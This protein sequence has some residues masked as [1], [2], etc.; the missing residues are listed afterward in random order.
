M[1]AEGTL[2]KMSRSLEQGEVNYSMN[3]GG[4]KIDMN[5]LIG[6]DLRFV[7]LNKINCTICGVEINHAYAGRAICRNCYE[8]A[9][10]AEECLFYPEKCMAHLG[11]ARDMAWSEKQ[12]LIPHFVYL[13]LSSGLKV[14]V[15]R[16]HQIPVR[17]IDQGAIRA[18]KLAETPNRHIA[19]VIE[20]FLK[21]HLA[22]KTNWKTMLKS[23][24]SDFDIDLLSEKRKATELLPEELKRYVTGND[25]VTKITYPFK[26]VPEEIKT[27]KLEKDKEAKGILKG[28]KGQYLIFDNGYV[29][30]MNR[31]SGYRV[32]MEY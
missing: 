21:G 23:D 28:I 19:G 30:N 10:E 16:N 12:C 3:L 11:E 5:A 9:P 27:V 7:F 4:N 25:E 24:P 6:K 2:D 26:D 13:A 31:Y 17:W 29:L 15:T 14:G 32:S 20:V 1:L 8:T 22:D 18:V